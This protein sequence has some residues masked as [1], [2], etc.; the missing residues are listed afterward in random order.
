M[1]VATVVTGPVQENCYVVL[2]EA[3][4]EAIIVDPGDDAGDIVGLV[5][6]LRATPTAIVNT[7]CHF[8]HVGAVEAMRRRFGIPFYIHPL[9][10]PMLEHAAESAARFGLRIEQ[11][12]IDRFVREGENVAVGESQLAVRFTPGHCPGHIVL[13]GDSFVLAG[14]VLFSGGVGRTDLPG[15]SWPQLEDSIR[16]Q[17]L[18]WPDATVIY[19]GH[20]PST[21]IGRERQTNPFLQ[22]I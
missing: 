12:R 19:P 11:P 13:V 9:D 15:A 14:D 6:R 8:D 10:Q 22:G 7:H 1:H 5:E 18:T 21:S 4:R 2:D 20:G 3:T 17:L 16:T